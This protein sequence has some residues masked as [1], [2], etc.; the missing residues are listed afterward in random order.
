MTPAKSDDYFESSRQPWPALIWV[1]PLV[2]AYEWR[3]GPLAGVSASPEALMAPTVLREWLSVAGVAGRLLPGVLVVAILAGWHVAMKGRWA[4]RPVTLA[5]M[6]GESLLWAAVLAASATLW[7]GYDPVLPTVRPE[8]VLSCIGAGVYEELL[9]RLIGLT[10]AVALLQDAAGLGRT[11]A[12]GVGIGV[13]AFMFALYHQ[14]GQETIALPLFVFHSF[15]GIV[16]GLLM[17]IR[18]FG[19]TALSH[20]IYNVMVA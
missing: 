15:A 6:G 4:V 12:V 17:H 2:V 7:F 20:V 19:I 14:L 9:F 18:G 11:T 3:C 10:A 8:I 13:T 1:A 16:L 5:G